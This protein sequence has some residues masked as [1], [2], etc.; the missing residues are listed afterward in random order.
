MKRSLTARLKHPITSALIIALGTWSAGCKPSPSQPPATAEKTAAAAIQAQ[1]RWLPLSA[2]VVSYWPSAQDIE[3]TLAGIQ[4]RWSALS[5]PLTALCT[6]RA[7]GPLPLCQPSRWTAFGVSPQAPIGVFL[8]QGLLGVSVSLEAPGQLTQQLEALRQDEDPWQLERSQDYSVI[9][10]P[11]GLS[12]GI[13]E[14]ERVA[15]LLFGLGGQRQEVEAWAQRLARAPSHEHWEQE[16]Q[17]RALRERLYKPQ[18]VFVAL[19]LGGAL[20]GLPSPT[21][22]ADALKGR[23]IELQDELGLS[24]RYKAD[25]QR[26]YA[27]LYTQDEPTEAT[28]VRDLRGALGELPELGALVWPG[29]L[30]VVRVSAQPEPLKMLWLSTLSLKQQQQLSEFERT[31]RDELSIDL[32]EALWGN[33]TGHMVTVLYGLNPEVFGQPPLMVL[34]DVF[35][36]KATREA[37]LLTLQEGKKLG[38]VLDAATQLSQGKLRRQAAEGATQYAWFERGELRWALLLHDDYVIW[39]DSPVAFTRASQQTRSSLPLKPTWQPT[40][41]PE[42]LKERDRS[43]VYLDMS[44]LLALLPDAQLEQVKPYLGPIKS[45]LLISDAMERASNIQLEITLK[46]HQ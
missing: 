14:R 34:R 42:L 18:E 7:Q 22:Q 45:A 38:D 4:T 41:L 29:A 19:D 10:L 44:A 24:L 6:A 15:L 11:G 13:L 26:L 37:A 27:T 3:R 33:L 16:A 32:E 12:V 40:H 9:N 30:G 23:L 21:P 39:I 28:V 1:G 8:Q 36:L 25:E 35:A 2:E 46:P 43:G 20:K 17:H 31:L 5:A